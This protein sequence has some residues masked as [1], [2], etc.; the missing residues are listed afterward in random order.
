MICT[1]LIL[2]PTSAAVAAERYVPTPITIE[3]LFDL[4][5][6]AV[7]AF[8]PGAYR[9]VEETRSS[10]GD[11]WTTETLWS[12][13]DFRATIRQG[14]FTIAFGSYGGQNWT[15]DDNGL[16]TRSN[17]IFQTGDLYAS[18]V[19]IPTLPSH[20]VTIL[21]MTQ[22][23]PT[24]I[25]VGT[26]PDEAPVQ[27]R[28]YDSHTF[29]LARRE[30]RD[31]DGHH[32]VWEYDDYRA[33]DGMTIPWAVRYLQDA[34]TVTRQTQLISLERLASTPDLSLP[35]S[36]SLFSLSSSPLTLSADFQEGGIFLPVVVNGRQIDFELDSGGDIVI[37]PGAAKELGM[38]L[39][40]STRLSFSGDYT[41]ADTRASTLSIGPLAAKNVAMAAIGFD[42]HPT[43]H[44]VRGLLGADF[45]G[46][47]AM[48]VSFSKRTITVYAAQPP[49]LAKQGWLGLP[50]QVD[51]GVPT[52]KAT[53]SGIEGNFVVDLSA[54]STILYPH[55][56]NGF[57]KTV[58]RGA[59]DT[60]EVGFSGRTFDLK[61]I[62]MRSMTLG[63]WVFRD[64]P[65]VVP[66]AQSAQ[67]ADYDGLIG[68]T[69][70]ANFDLIFD[71]ANRTLW[72]RPVDFK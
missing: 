22:S 30:E 5:R 21:G 59:P 71:L 46:S 24:E 4:N 58:A 29:L 53:F 12:G 7:G 67:D 48:E 25:V 39:S 3:Q 31:Y 45:I 62:T 61:S 68:L 50:I 23:D 8:A 60:S 65:V 36:R 54:Y 19:R 15:Q 43:G 14:G 11:V 20:A 6:K 37:D 10:T 41:V 49:D 56:F 42:R 51:D 13:A 64:V 28:Y 32:Q 33:I 1:L 35:A 17:A 63:D 47:G 57:G 9:S 18:A 66:S 70:L 27:Q 52:I 16:V 40:G 72:L 2:L 38:T 26:S 55:F 69:T 34:S 44:R